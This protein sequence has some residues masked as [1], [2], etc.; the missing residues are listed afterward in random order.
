MRLYLPAMMSFFITCGV[1]KI[2]LEDFHISFLSSV[3]VSPV[4]SAKPLPMVSLS[5]S[6]SMSLSENILRC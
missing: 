4:K 2:T 1:A 5:A 3:G 6:G